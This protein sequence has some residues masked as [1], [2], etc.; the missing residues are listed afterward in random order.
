MLFFNTLIMKDY[1]I[2]TALQFPQKYNLNNRDVIEN[3][4]ENSACHVR[5]KSHFTIY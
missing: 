3:E 4:Y 5:N 2:K 1:P